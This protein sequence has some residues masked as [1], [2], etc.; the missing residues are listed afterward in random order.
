M[1]FKQ[2]RKRFN[3]KNIEV[4]GAVWSE[5]QKRKGTERGPSDFRAAG[6]LKSLKKSLDL[7]IKD[8]G[9]ITLPEDNPFEYPKK[10]DL[11]T[12]AKI[13]YLNGKLSQKIAQ[14]SK[15]VTTLILG[16]DHSLG[17]GSI[18]GQLLKHGDDLRVIWVDAHADINTPKTSDTKNYHGMPLA[19]ILGFMDEDSYT[20]FEWMKKRLNPKNLVLLGIRDLDAAEKKTIADNGIMAI[21]TFE[22][23]DL[24]GMKWAVEEAFKY[25]GIDDKKLPLHVSFD[26]DSSDSSV[27]GGTGTPSRY[28]LTEREI[29]YLMRKVSGSECLVN[30]DVAEMNT[31]IEFDGKYQKYHGDNQLLHTESLSLYNA[32]E[33]IHYALGKKQV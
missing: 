29:I 20:G 7:Q 14:T 21:S 4:I 26:V 9:D 5:G 6:L 32:C 1:L 10:H 12:Y 23:D 17:S 3:S 27:V 30:L 33:F 25:L 28:G 13:G 31:S 19:H 2:I 16:G 15:N 11:D 22:I 24:G 8:L 18:H